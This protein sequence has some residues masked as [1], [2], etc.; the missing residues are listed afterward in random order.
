MARD[1]LPEVWDGF[2]EETADLVGFLTEIGASRGR[3]FPAMGGS[4]TQVVGQTKAAGGI[5]TLRAP[6][7]SDDGARI[8]LQSLKRDGRRIAASGRGHRGAER[9]GPCGERHAS[10][11]A[12]RNGKSP[13]ASSF[14]AAETAGARRPQRDRRG[15]RSRRR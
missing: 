15:R 10:G 14:M 5:T 1:F 4:F 12:T 6:E 7:R 11:P 3:A 8:R 9:P 2:A 13:P